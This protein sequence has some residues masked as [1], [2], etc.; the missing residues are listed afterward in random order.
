MP[1]F[2]ECK[3]FHRSARPSFSLK[4]VCF[5]ILLLAFSE[6]SPPSSACRFRSKCQFLAP[7]LVFVAESFCF[8]RIGIRSPKRLRHLTL[9]PGF[10]MVCLRS[11]AS[12][13]ALQTLVFSRVAACLFRQDVAP[14]VSR[15]SLPGVL[16]SS[17]ILVFGGILLSAEEPRHFYGVFLSPRCSY[18][19]VTRICRRLSHRLLAL[20]L[21]LC[22]VFSS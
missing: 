15:C 21:L 17:R 13:S 8:R 2:A 4:C 22:V 5:L 20:L 19:C 12:A 7:V 6:M 16:L 9:S 18:C 3:A 10:A 11:V 1:V 14:P